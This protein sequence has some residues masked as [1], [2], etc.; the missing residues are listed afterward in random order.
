MSYYYVELT[1]VPITL[2]YSCHFEFI[3]VS[4]QVW[5]S[6]LWLSIEAHSFTVINHWCVSIPLHILAWLQCG[7]GWLYTSVDMA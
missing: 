7:V 3:T 2:Q 4:I 6:V 5:H 1:M